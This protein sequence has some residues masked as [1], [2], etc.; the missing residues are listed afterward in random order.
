MSGTRRRPGRL[1]PFV[2]GYRVWLLAAGYTPQTVR[3][4]LKDLG[5]LGRWM[6]SED[7]EVGAVTIAAIES[8]LADWRAA[9]G[10]RVPT[11]RAL[12]SLLTFLR[13]AGVMVGAEPPVLS[14]VEA[15]VGEYREWLVADRGLAAMTVLRYETLARR[16]LTGRVS[17]T[18]ELGVAGLN[19]AVV[20]RFLLAE[21]ERVCSRVREG[22]GRRAA[23]AVAVPARAWVHVA[24]AGGVGSRRRGVAGDDD[25]AEH[26]PVGHRPAAGELRPLDA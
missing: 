1:G 25:P 24:V 21:C 22:K 9:G 15:L 10:R 2:E 11:V 14:P 6:D 7:V 12:R 4:M 20:S 5:R 8:F 13:E 16:F 19:G 3:P 18:D 17:P 23:V 26:A